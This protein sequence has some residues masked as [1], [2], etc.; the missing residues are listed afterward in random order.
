LS[1][2]G[3]ESN[4]RNGA[5]EDYKEENS[6]PFL[7]PFLRFSCSI[8]YLLFTEIMLQQRRSRGIKSANFGA[9]FPAAS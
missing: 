4:K 8:I 3:E 1:G 7:S 6:S 5:T 9:G 2:I